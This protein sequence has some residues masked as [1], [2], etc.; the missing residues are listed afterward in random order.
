[1]STLSILQE[2]VLSVRNEMNKL[3]MIVATL[4]LM[5]CATADDILSKYMV[6]NTCVGIEKEMHTIAER[7]ARINNLRQVKGYAIAG[8]G[9][10]VTITAIPPVGLVV[11]GSSFL[12]E[13]QI[14]TTAN[15]ER[16]EYLAGV[17]EIRGCLTSD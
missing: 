14:N 4:V 3:F 9:I 8:V 7:I 1:M 17:K 6:P 10:G 12:D 13:F 2:Y 15:H 11:A 16:L 5:G